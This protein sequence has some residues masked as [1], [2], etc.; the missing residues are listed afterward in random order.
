MPHV[1]RERLR[2]KKEKSSRQAELLDREKRESAER[3]QWI[4]RKLLTAISTRLQ[5]Q[6]S[7]CRRNI[8]KSK[9]HFPTP[10]LST[11]R[12]IVVSHADSS[13]KPTNRQVRLHSTSTWYDSIS[14]TNPE[15]LKIAVHHDTSPNPLHVNHNSI[16]QAPTTLPQEY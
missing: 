4:P 2:V 15:T 7:A 8:M 16:L 5:G 3:G 1:R 11:L 9:G 10:D 14:R 13:R 6:A 12:D